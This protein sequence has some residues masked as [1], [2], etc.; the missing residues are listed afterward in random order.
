[1]TKPI[2]RC[3]WRSAGQLALV[4][5]MLEFPKVPNAAGVYRFTLDAATGMQVYVGQSEGLRGRFQHYRTPGGPGERRTTKFRLNKL[6]LDTLSAGGRVTVDV[7]TQAADV[8]SDGTSVVLD[9]S[10]KTVRSRVERAI[11]ATERASGS[12]L[13]NRQT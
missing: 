2:V 4:N 13:L 11:Q 10:Q 5:G 7:A 1:M 9:L 3:S 8:A 12:K 6:M